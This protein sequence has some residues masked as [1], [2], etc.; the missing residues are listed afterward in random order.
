MRYI[1]DAYNLAFKMSIKA[2][3]MEIPRI[4]GTMAP[5]TIRQLAKQGGELALIAN[6]VF[7]SSAR[8]DT[9]GKGASLRVEQVAFNGILRQQHLDALEN[10][11]AEGCGS[12]YQSSDTV[13]QT[14]TEVLYTNSLDE[15]TA[16]QD[17]KLLERMGYAIFD[18]LF[19][20][21]KLQTEINPIERDYTFEALG[22]KILSEFDKTDMAIKKLQVGLI[23]KQEA[24]MESENI[25]QAEADIRVENVDKANDEAMEKN[26]SFM[27]QFSQGE[28][29]ETEGN[30][31]G[32]N[33]DHNLRIKED[34]DNGNT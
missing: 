24:L 26:A 30:Q 3:I 5:Q 11:Y 12:N 16:N 29:E 9:E 19:V 4:M 33:E 20:A 21:K 10:K 15:K 7:I 14:A 28:Q 18:T 27:S 31:E 25:T 6:E 23:T 32:D 8:T 17:I 34:D 13:M 22:N 2:D 1:M